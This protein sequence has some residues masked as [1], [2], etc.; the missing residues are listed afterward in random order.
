MKKSCSFE[1]FLI[2]GNPVNPK[3]IILFEKKWCFEKA[4]RCLNNFHQNLLV[5]SLGVPSNK[6]LN[7]IRKF[8]KKKAFYFGDM[9][10]ESIYTFLTFLFLKRRPSPKNKVKWT[11]KFGGLTLSDYK[12]YLKSKDNILI[13]LSNSEKDIL[14]Y[15]KDFKLQNLKRELQFLIRNNVKIEIEAINSY[16]FDNYLK[17]K[18]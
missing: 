6:C 14:E 1:D 8:E 7:F 9:D 18:V 2:C 10:P 4:V 3:R 5:C 12:K 15:I 17:D 13:K 11:V 16:G